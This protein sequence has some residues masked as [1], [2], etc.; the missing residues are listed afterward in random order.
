M[1]KLF[2]TKGWMT[3]AQLARA[4][5]PELAEDGEN[6]R[7]CEQNLIHLLLEDII[8]GRL[9]NSGPLVDGRRLGLVGVTPENKASFVE[10]PKLVDLIRGDKTFVLHNILVMKE[11]VLDFAKRHQLPLPSWWADSA[12]TPNEALT[13]TKVN[14]V[15]PNTGAVGKQPR[16][17]KLLCEHFPD[18]VPGPGLCPRQ[19]LKSDIL[20]WDPDLARLDEATLKKAIDKYNASLAK[21]KS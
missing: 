12:S 17:L 20:K 21:Q 18:G 8:N 15:K 10:G 13:D 16:I 3:I 7:D 19:S 5:S 4:W 1:S 2:S 9:D 11:A 14:V 6:P